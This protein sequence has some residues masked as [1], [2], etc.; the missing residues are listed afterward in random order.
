MNLTPAQFDEKTF[1]PMTISS[2]ILFSFL[3]LPKHKH[4]NILNFSLVV[5]STPTH[6][7]AVFQHMHLVIFKAF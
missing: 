1:E 2:R 3:L 5:S 4:T 6:G 7:T